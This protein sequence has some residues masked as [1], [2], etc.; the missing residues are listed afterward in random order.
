MEDVRLL[1]D[2][3]SND[4]PASPPAPKKGLGQHLRGKFR[5]RD[6]VKEEST[7]L[8]SRFGLLGP[9]LKMPYIYW[10]QGKEGLI[11]L[12]VINKE[13][14]ASQL[15]MKNFHGI[16]NSISLNFSFKALHHE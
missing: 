3:L 4:T 11:P 7:L 2:P 14:K 1:T 15:F 5:L 16:R 13:D 10:W 6:V 9:N 12:A 8:A